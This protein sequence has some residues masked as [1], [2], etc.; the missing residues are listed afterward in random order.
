MKREDKV[1]LIL[2]IFSMWSQFAT[3]QVDNQFQYN[4]LKPQNFQEGLTSDT[5]QFDRLYI[6]LPLKDGRFISEQDIN[7]ENSAIIGDG[8]D[9][10]STR[11]G[12]NR[13]RFIR[14]FNAPSNDTVIPPPNMLTMGIV[15]MSGYDSLGF[16]GSNAGMWLFSL[17]DTATGDSTWSKTYNGSVVDLKAVS[18][19]DTNKTQMSYLSIFGDNH[20]NYGLNAIGLPKKEKHNFYGDANF[21]NDLEVHDTLKVKKYMEGFLESSATKG[22]ALV[23]NDSGYVETTD[24]LVPER[25]VIELDFPSIDPNNTGELSV[26][27]PCDLNDAVKA[28]PIGIEIEQ[29][30][31]I[32]TT[33]YIQTD[34]EVVVRATN[35]GGATVDPDPISFTIIVMRMP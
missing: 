5:S 10:Y 28:T 14:N 2:L 6:N 25:R 35:V 23:A 27:M 9:I 8:L 4:W 17:V 29:Y 16:Q 1:L 15:C 31:N 33:S 22:Q 11:V 18:P 34:G 13:I 19:T 3:A 21:Q 20:I 7:R 32:V 24:I 26:L 30:G 12:S